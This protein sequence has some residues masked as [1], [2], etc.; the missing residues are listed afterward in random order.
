MKIE[1]LEIFALKTP[2]KSPIS[3]TILLSLATSP[4][5]FGI[6]ILAKIDQ[7]LIELGEA[8]EEVFR[9]DRLPVLPR[10][11][12]ELKKKDLSET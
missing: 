4:F 9:G 12:G 3:S 1:L 7:I 6:A 8:T 5:V 10:K 2:N 11:N